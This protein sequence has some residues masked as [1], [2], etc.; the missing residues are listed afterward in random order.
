MLVERAP[1][2]QR[3]E[4]DLLVLLGHRI[5]EMALVRG[6]AEQLGDAAVE[7]GG[8]CAIALRL[9][10]E[11]VVRVDI[12]V[13]I[14]LDERLERDFEALAII[15][16]R[17]VVIGNAPRAGIDVEAGI[18]GAILREAAELDIAVAAAQGPA[19]PAGAPAIFEDLHFVAG[20]AQLER[21]YHAGN[22]GAEDQHRGALR[23]AVEAERSLV[24]GGRRVTQDGHRLIPHTGASRRAD[25]REEIAPAQRG[26]AVVGQRITPWPEPAPAPARDASSWQ[27][28]PR[29]NSRA[30]Q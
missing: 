25:R 12:G 27:W 24:V 18:E 22:P 2:A 20:L 30:A 4:Q 29:C 16:Q 10:A 11:R 28:R 6:I 7:I 1:A 15:E 19:P 14:D 13:V 8:D 21:R 5:V 26:R 23:I 9:A 3:L 17:A